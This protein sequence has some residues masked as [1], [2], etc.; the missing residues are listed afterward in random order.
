MPKF[1]SCCYSRPLRRR[2]RNRAIFP[3]GAFQ[4][5]AHPSRNGVSVVERAFANR[6]GRALEPMSLTIWR[7][8]AS[9]RRFTP[10]ALASEMRAAGGELGING[11][12]GGNGRPTH[13]QKSAKF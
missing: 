1:D 10:S 12:L 6:R 5:I 9:R 8:L 7:G 3:A 11:G 13:M 4:E 2:Q